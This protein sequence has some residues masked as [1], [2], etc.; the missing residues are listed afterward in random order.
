MGLE[1]TWRWFGPQDQDARTGWNA[2][3]SWNCYENN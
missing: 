1:K 3:Y 2:N